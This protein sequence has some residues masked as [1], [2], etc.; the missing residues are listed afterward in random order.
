[1]ATK[2]QPP[3]VFADVAAAVTDHVRADRQ[4]RRNLPG[5]GRIHLDRA[6]PFLVLYRQPPGVLDQGTADLATAFSAHCTAS[7]DPRFHDGL[8]S[9]VLTLAEAER[10][11]HGAFLLVEIWARAETVEDTRSPPAGLPDATVFPGSDEVAGVAAAMATALGALRLEPETGGELGV[12]DRLSWVD[13]SAGRAGAPPGMHPLLDEGDRVGT[14]WT[15]LE[16]APFYRDADTSSPFPRV[17]QALRRALAKAVEQA[18]FLFAQN[19]TSLDPAHPRALG[20]TNAERAALHVDRRLGEVHATFDTLL[21]VTPINTEEAWEE[22]KE[23]GFDRAPALRY[24][25]LPFD[26]EHLKRRLF[27]VPMERVEAPLLGYLFREKLEE[28]DREITMLRALGTHRFFHASAE[29][30]GLPD[31]GLV[32]L[33]E[34]IL[35][36]L[37]PAEAVGEFEEYPDPDDSRTARTPFVDAV[38]FARQARA[39]ITRY[40]RQLPDFPATVEIRTGIASGL[41]VVKGV[42]YVSEHLRVPRERVRALINHEIGTHLVTYRNGVAQ[43]LRIFASGLA[44]YDALQEGLAVLAEY[45]VGG[46][47]VART[48][49]LAGRVLAVRSIAQGGSFVDTFRLLRQVHG[50]QPRTA[51]VITLRVHRGGGLTKDAAYLAGLRDLLKHLRSAGSLDTLLVGKVGLA[52]AE[53][54]QELVLTGVLRLPVVRPFYISELA[55]ME[56]LGPLRNMDVMDLVEEVRA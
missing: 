55:T 48:R 20:R 44:G 54:V 26:P 37:P 40:R 32:A 28:M 41:M 43:P 22:F 39:E 53:I 27:H 36:R 8:K 14:F 52:H 56:R 15:G 16:V 5:N 45:L 17:L 19:E 18:V 35:E 11:R 6:L 12:A 47:T 34:R 38:E 1:M 50:F 2:P 25:P 30:F 29:L 4:L 23:S 9:V 31:E 24:R 10:A 42:L 21:Q 51:F 33:A 49:V 7:G 46:L 3:S 13:V